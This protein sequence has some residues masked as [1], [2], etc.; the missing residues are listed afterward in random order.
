MTRPELRVGGVSPLT[1]IDYPGEL[2]AVVFCQ[3]CPWRCHYCHNPELLPARGVAGIAWGRVLD[4]LQRRRGLLDAVVFSG[5]EPTLQPALAPAILQV[6]ELGFRI[7]LHTAGMYPK[8]LKA[9]LPLLDWVGLDIKA[10]P[11]RYA[12]ITQVRRSGGAAWRS[13]EIIAASGVAHEVRITQYRPAI[14]AEHLNALQRKLRAL[15]VENM[16]VQ[17]CRV[18]EVRLS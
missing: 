17:P 18:P 12:E 10:L 14:D 13:A 3:G 1:T 8:R 5:G 11:D 6:R 7:G 15:G 9:L 4:F 2:A 16:R